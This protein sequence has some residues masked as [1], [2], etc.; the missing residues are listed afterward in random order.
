VVR[1][2]RRGRLWRHH[3]EHFHAL[4]VLLN[5]RTIDVSDYRAARHQRGI[6]HTF[7]QF[8]SGGTPRGYFAGKAGDFDLNTTRHRV[9]NLV[10]PPSAN[11]SLTFKRNLETIA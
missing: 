10:G 11:I 5:V 7:G 8:R 3:R 1:I 4:H 6:E 2:Q 9:S